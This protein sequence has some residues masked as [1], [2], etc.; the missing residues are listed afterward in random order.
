MRSKGRWAMECG[1]NVRL[2]AWLLLG[3]GL[4][5]FGY[6]TGWQNGWDAASARGPRLDVAAESF[7]AMYPRTSEEDEV[8][9]LAAGVGEEGEEGS[10][11]G[12]GRTR[13]ATGLGAGS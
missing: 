4:C 10:I 12:L 2:L 13:D 9:I 1:T 5:A 11:D 6:A 3:V 7:N 8:A